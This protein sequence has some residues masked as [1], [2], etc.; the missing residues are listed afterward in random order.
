MK[1][2]DYIEDI[3]LKNIEELNDNEPMEGH[4]ARFEAKLNAQNKKTKRI[5]FS[6]VWKVAAAVVFVL[7]AG[8]QAF[9]YLSPNNQGIFSAANKTQEVT[10]ASISNEYQEVEFYYTSSINSGIDQWNKLNDAGLISED[11]QLMMNEELAEFETLYKNLQEDLQSNPND[12]RVINAMLEYY[13]AKLSVINI[14]VDKLEEVKQ[15]NEIEY[16]SL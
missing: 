4:F 13:Q 16:E 10:L 8:N 14:I 12:D 5:T 15:R 11:E 7:L 1:E 3:I 2:K 9:M 6:I